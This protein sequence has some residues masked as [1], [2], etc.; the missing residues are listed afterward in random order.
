MTIASRLAAPVVVRGAMIVSGLGIATLTGHEGLS[1][2]GYLDSVGVPTVCYGHTRTAVVGQRF[3]Q[4]RCEELLNEDLAEFAAT[5]NKNIKV[6]LS[7]P[8]FDALVSFCYNVGSH[9]C[10]TSTM[11]R[12]I[13]DGDYLGGAAQFDR[14]Y[15]AGGRDCRVR[16]NNCYGVWTRRMAEKQLFLS[17]T[18]MTNKAKY[19]I[20]A[21]GE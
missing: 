6:D 19:P 8:Q 5:V 9:A 17:G 11:F 15:R 1:Y 18:T 2:T 10:K 3:S 16:R 14:W 20:A 7:Q 4:E 21:T 12:L 13:N